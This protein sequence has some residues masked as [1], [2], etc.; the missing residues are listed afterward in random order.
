M[1]YQRL[2]D[3]VSSA[4]MRIGHDHYNNWKNTTLNNLSIE[5]DLSSND[6]M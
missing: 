4:M 1:L 3:S 5:S 2:P 6:D